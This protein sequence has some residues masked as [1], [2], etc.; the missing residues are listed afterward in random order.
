MTQRTEVLADTEHGP[1]RG[2]VDGD[3]AVFRGIPFA[4]A[5]VGPLRFAAPEPPESWSA[6]LD[7]EIPGPA[8]PQ[9]PS[10]MAAILGSEKLP[11]SD[12][13]NC[14]TLNVFT[15]NVIGKRAVLVW[16][17]GGGFVTGYGGGERNSGARLAENEDIVVVCP[18][19]RIG[20]FGYLYLGAGQG[21]M[22][23]L[24]QIAA[25]QWVHR[26]IAAFGGD[27]ER[28]TVGGHSAGALSAAAVAA[29]P[30]ARGLVRRVLLA[31]P[32]LTNIGT[33]QQASADAEALLTALGGGRAE[34]QAATAGQILDAAAKVTAAHGEP[35]PSLVLG[36]AELPVAIDA[37][38]RAAGVDVLIGTTAEEAR[39]FLANDPGM[40]AVDERTALGVLGR[41]RPGAEEVLFQHYSRRRPGGRPG[42]LVADALT[43]VLFRMPALR[44]AQEL[45]AYTY[46]FD[47]APN[48]AL[49]SCHTADI[50]FVLGN[51]APWLETP[52]LAGHTLEQAQPLADAYSGALAEFIREG[53]APWP[54]YDRDRR[55]TMRFGALTGWVDDAAGPERE[56]WGVV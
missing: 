29:A 4:A 32:P 56:L 14:L 34:L 38:L 15:P 17:H 42:E 18:N 7:A 40:A 8:V 39:A 20:P 9:N 31:S 51:P 13:D 27:P 41:F 28:I 6:A 33:P 25:L 16:L 43:D 5:P 11:G 24:D 47:W 48:P 50:P 37:G 53:R 55:R 30:S 19:Y 44:I 10:P 46:Q 49:G 23:L 35:R 52:L 1:V 36:G 12:E 26:N 54:R 2:L 45:T 22:G 3:L 21:N